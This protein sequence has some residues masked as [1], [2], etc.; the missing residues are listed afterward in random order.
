MTAGLAELCQKLGYSF[1]D[2]MLLQQALT[3]RSYS[4]AH[5]ERLEFLGDALLDM[6]IAERLYKEC[7]NINEGGLSRLRATLVNGDTLTELACELT[8]DQYLLLGPG[9]T[10][11]GNIRRSSILSTTM[12]ALIGAIYLDGGLAACR[13]HV[14]R[15]YAE[16]LAHI[17]TTDI[18]K[19]PKTQLQE[20][21]QAQKHALPRYQ[22]TAITGK[23][24]LQTFTVRC[25]MP[26]T[27]HSALGYG[28]N[29]RRAEQD[30]A[31]QLLSTL[32]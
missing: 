27:T 8:V 22:V 18:Q 4:A 10:K 32:R 28:P 31:K 3:H 29:R 6:L 21:A 23:E 7:P 12:E 19:D 20:Y 17:S 1:H 13:K 26:N 5:N 11:A 14:Y 25:Y 2:P 16:R 15:W 9:E 30:A 24:H